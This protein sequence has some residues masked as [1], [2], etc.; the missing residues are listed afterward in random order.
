VE[1]PSS[2]PNKKDSAERTEPGSVRALLCSQGPPNE[3]SMES[4]I[5][6]SCPIPCSKVL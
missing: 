6:V 4:G 1:M 5:S 3:E 2:L